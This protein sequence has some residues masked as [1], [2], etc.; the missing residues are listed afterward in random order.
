MEVGNSYNQNYQN[1]QSKRNAPILDQGYSSSG[2]TKKKSNN[3]YSNQSQS[4]S[5]SSTAPVMA[6]NIRNTEALNMNYKNQQF[7]PNINQKEIP[8]MTE[9]PAWSYREIKYDEFKHPR[10]TEVVTTKNIPRK[11]NIVE[12]EI[13][14]KSN[15]EIFQEKDRKY[16]NNIKYQKVKVTKKVKG[17]GNTIPRKGPEDDMEQK[18]TL[19][20][21]ENINNDNQNYENNNYLLDNNNNNYNNNPYEDQNNFNKYN[22]EENNGY[23]MNNNYE[24]N[25]EQNDDGLNELLEDKETDNNLNQNED[26]ELDYIINNNNNNVNNNVN[27]M[28]QNDNKFNNDEFQNN[29]N[30]QLDLDTLEEANSVKNQQL[31][32]NEEEEYIPQLKNNN[33][34]DIDNNYEDNNN[35]IQE[36]NNYE[37]N[38]QVKP[39]PTFIKTTSKK[40][41]DKIDQIKTVPEANLEKWNLVAD[42]TP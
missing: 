30:Y 1:F 14:R 23:N 34:D 33:D 12:P 32:E 25:N 18:N 27:N 6:N 29:E 31:E 4:Y 16:F 35:E 10:N 11:N 2:T 20:N 5:N 21:Y 41:K 37:N 17:G 26:E 9:R 38:N 19:Q 24:N 8:R 40:V 36:S 28:E 15:A 3:N 22:E 13:P 7:Q 39:R 42:Y